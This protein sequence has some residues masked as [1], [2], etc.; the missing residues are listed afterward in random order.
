[1]TRRRVSNPLAL[2]VLALTLEKPMHPYEM[3]LTLR[4]RSKEGSVRLNY[5]SLYSVVD[6]LVRHHLIEPVETVREGRR[7]ERTVYR[8]TAAGR[9]EFEDW[10]AELIGQPVKEYTRFEAGLAFLPGLPPDDVL[11]LLEMRCRLL[12]MELEKYD[13]SLRDALEGGLPRLLVIEWE[14]VATQMRAELEWAERLAEEI[15]NGTLQGLDTW[16]SYH[17]LRTEDQPDD[18]TD[19]DTGEDHTGQARDPERSETSETSDTEDP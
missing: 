7:P 5:G 19:E 3:S 6:K 1:M 8:A 13:S 15:R 16:R 14:Y 4:E 2:A 11:R 17:D 10:L 9:A 12:A 18:H